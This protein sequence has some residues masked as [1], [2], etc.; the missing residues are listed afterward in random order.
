MKS[1][2]LWL[3]LAAASGLIL[4]GCSDDGAEVADIAP[5]A[6]TEAAPVFDAKAFFE[7]TTY[8][9]ARSTDHAFSPDGA[10]LLASSDATGVFNAYSISVDSGKAEPLT[11]STTAATY[12]IS[13]FPADGRVLYTAD[14]GGDE[15]NHIYVR[16]ENG[17]TR[18]LTPGD[19][20]KAA[21][22]RWSGDGS[23]FWVLT[24]ERDANSF[25]LYRY[26]ATDYA[27]EMVYE[28]ETSF[29]ISAV[30][31]DGKWLAVGRPESSAN[32]N[33]YLIDLSSE[34]KEAMLMTAHEGDI[35]YN[36]MTFTPDSGALIFS[37]NEHG[38]FR[39]A[40]S[41]GLA[42]GAQSELVAADWDVVFVT[43]SPSGRYRVSAVNEDASIK[44]TIFDT[45]E[46]QELALGTLPA[47]DLRNIRFSNDE[48]G[49][50]F[51]INSDTSPSNVHVVNLAGGGRTQLTQALNPAIRE[52]DLV[53]GEIIRYASF[54]GLEI[55]SVLYKPHGASASNPAP[56]LVW[57]HGGPGGQSRKGYRAAVQHLVNNGYAVLMANNRGSSGYGK[58]YF[59]LDDRNHGE[60]DLSDIVHGRTYLETL[61]WVD[62]GKIGIIGGSYGGYMVGAALA[63]EPEV[64]DVGINIFGVMNWVR[65]LQ[66]IPP[67]WS[68]QKK[69]L[70]DE[71]GD[72]ATDAE[73]HERISPLFHAENIVKPMLVVQGANDPRVLQRESDEIVAAVRANGVPVEYI[74]FPD[75]GHGFRNRDNRI[76]ASNAYVEF[77]DLYLKGEGGVA[78]AASD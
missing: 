43:Y 58:T 64:F 4:A 44:V 62:D 65:T 42:D 1:R 50:A 47:G 2:H 48:S 29:Q 49:M 75:E 15:L 21:F 3:T 6:G 20:L 14:G 36:A 55:P 53:D 40:W 45:M 17:E 59:H 32:S 67:W 7:T 24:N 35:S 74:V 69:A 27:R 46:G 9:N 10:R 66:N 28:N 73:R 52:S 5:A 61:D 56:A 57:V 51:L 60:G 78:S 63:F 54:D 41:H 30:S 38:E 72:P 18:D 11:A 23:G 70:F 31:P 76:T 19:K 37:T 77:L 16:E 26:S 39:Q 68:S 22:A 13:Y 71:M 33:L 34:A 25:D 12:G 8:L